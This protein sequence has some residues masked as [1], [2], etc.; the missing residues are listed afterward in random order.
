MKRRRYAAILDKRNPLKC[1]Y[2]CYEKIYE[3]EERT[4]KK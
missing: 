4:K 2:Y 3:D 1:V